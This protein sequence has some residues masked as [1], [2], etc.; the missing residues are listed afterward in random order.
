[1]TKRR[2]SKTDH[3]E[4]AKRRRLSARG[5]TSKDES[6]NTREEFVYPPLDH[7]TDSIRV[8]ELHPGPKDSIIRCTMHNAKIS[9]EAHICLSY[10]WQPSNPRHTIEVNGR[11]HTVGENLHQF[12]R[13]YRIYMTRRNATDRD[14]PLW[15]DALCINQIDTKEK[16]HQ[17]Q[18][19]G[20]I[21]CNAAKVLV[22]LGVLDNQLRNFLRSICLDAET[23]RQ[24]IKRKHYSPRPNPWKAWQ[25]GFP[26]ADPSEKLRLQR[27]TRTLATAEYWA[28]I[29]VAQELLL[30]GEGRV[31]L[32]EGWASYEL[33]EL[34]HPLRVIDWTPQDYK[35]TIM[36]C[37]DYMSRRSTMQMYFTDGTRL[38]VK[39]YNLSSLLSYLASCGC[40]D[41]RDRVF[42]LIPLSTFKGNFNIDYKNDCSTLFRRVLEHAMSYESLRKNTLLRNILAV[43]KGLDR[44]YLGLITKAQVP[45]VASRAKESKPLLQR[46]SV[47]CIYVKLIDGDDVHVFEYAIKESV[48]SVSVRYAR[49]YEYLRGTPQMSVHG[50]AFGTDQMYFWLDVPSEDVY[51]YIGR[52]YERGREEKANELEPALHEWESALER[53]EK[54]DPHKQ[55]HIKSGCSKAGLLP[56]SRTSEIMN[57]ST[58]SFTARFPLKFPASTRHV[59]SVCAYVKDHGHGP[60]PT[61]SRPCTVRPQ[62]VRNT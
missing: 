20:D 40:Q 34:Y 13:A 51:Y 22:W 17:V 31:F 56:A 52:F 27:H 24:S 2:I 4:A 33:G 37:M 15:V 21:Y 49:A 45:L 61:I 42:A 26:E 6:E 36:L 16:N 32:F 25:G 18:H 19:M 58:T 29:W 12:L 10:T 53:L 38:S 23:T 47:V 14:S 8:F 5:K 1:M 50:D 60:P 3:P 54:S 41:L 30:P 35:R 59:N 7:G 43:L 28:R 46:Q 44:I 55:S 9:D 48:T 11:S 57:L 39:R 62:W